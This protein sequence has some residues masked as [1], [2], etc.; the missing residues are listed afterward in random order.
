MLIKSITQFWYTI[1]AEMVKVQKPTVIRKQVL[2]CSFVKY[3]V[4]KLICK[5]QGSWMYI[6]LY[7][8]RY[9]LFQNQV[10]ECPSL[11]EVE[12]SA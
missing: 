6:F 5:I 11:T 12:S 1:I 2:G 7:T 4:K 9:L 8:R 3:H 10:S